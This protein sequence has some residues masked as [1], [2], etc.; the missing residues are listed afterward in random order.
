MSNINDNSGER[1]KLR[2]VR[3]DEDLEEL[4]REGGNTLT[5]CCPLWKAAL[6]NPVDTRELGV[7]V[8]SVRF[9]PAT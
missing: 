9:S 7:P 6:S 2:L 1:P 3:D 4:V 5:I 8:K